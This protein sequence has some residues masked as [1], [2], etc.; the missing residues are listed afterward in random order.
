M[1]MKRLMLI[2][3]AIMFFSGCAM[4]QPK[5]EVLPDNTFSCTHPSLKLKLD[6]EFK[7]KG[8]VKERS[9]ATSANNFLQSTHAT[10]EYFIWSNEDND[11]FI[12]IGFS[13]LI[14][15]SWVW[16]P[17]HYFAEKYKNQVKIENLGGKKWHTLCYDI[18]L[19]PGLKSELGKKD[20]RASGKYYIKAF[21]GGGRTQIAISIYYF[22]KTN[23]NLQQNGTDDITFMN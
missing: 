1:N 4:L 7:Y 8:V 9:G 15:S 23:K 18:N 10:N 20:V 21:K 13:K 3:I 11:P 14:D 17:K 19:P 16:L 2:I 12:I 5:R 6:E 22:T